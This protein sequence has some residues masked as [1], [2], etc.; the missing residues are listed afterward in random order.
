MMEKARNIMRIRV[1]LS[2]IALCLV[3][4]VFAAKSGKKA[5]ARGESVTQNNLNWHAEYNKTQNAQSSK[6][7]N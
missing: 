1:N 6:P 7:E 2:I 5:A 4:A 3:G